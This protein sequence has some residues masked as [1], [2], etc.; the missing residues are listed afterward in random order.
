MIISAIKLLFFSAIKIFKIFNSIQLIEVEKKKF[1]RNRE[2]IGGKKR[3]NQ[4]GSNRRNLIEKRE[5]KKSNS[6]NDNIGRSRYEIRL[7]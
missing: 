3:I 5:R 6:F 2:E 1:S 7:N 4:T